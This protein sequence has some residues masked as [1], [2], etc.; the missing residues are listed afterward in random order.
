MIHAKTNCDGFKEQ[1]ITFP[2]SVMQGTLLKEFYEEVGISPTSLDYLEAHATGTRVGD[3]EEVSALDKV[4]CTGRKEP[5]WVGSIKSNLGH[6]EPASGL[7]SIVKV[8]YLYKN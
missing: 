2:S 6:S 5:L 7:C 8:R 4:F 3:P 1:G